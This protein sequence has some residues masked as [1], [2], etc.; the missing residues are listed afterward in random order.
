MFQVQYFSK[1]ANSWIKIS[2]LVYETKQKAQEFI[3]YQVNVN[4]WIN[5]SFRIVKV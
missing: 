3:D 2:N 4:Q 1:F 5:D